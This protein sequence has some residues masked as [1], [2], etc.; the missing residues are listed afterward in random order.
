MNPIESFVRANR[1]LVAV[2][3]YWGKTALGLPITDVQ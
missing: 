2:G 3:W 1:E